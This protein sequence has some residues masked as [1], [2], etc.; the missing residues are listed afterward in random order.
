[1]AMA[2]GVHMLVNMRWPV[3]QRIVKQR[4]QRACGQDAESATAAKNARRIVQEK[5]R[6]V[7][8]RISSVAWASSPGNVLI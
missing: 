7:A 6:G 5:T 8:A 2:V 1:M 3:I 4:Q